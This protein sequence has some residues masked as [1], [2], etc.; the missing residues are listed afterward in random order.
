MTKKRRSVKR[1][2]NYSKCIYCG[3][4]DDLDEHRC[5]R[6]TRVDEL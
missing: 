2:A 5:P 6:G 4:W 1:P 3:E